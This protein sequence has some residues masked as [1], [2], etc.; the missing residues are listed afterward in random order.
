MHR[1]KHVLL[2][3]LIRYAATFYNTFLASVCLA[4]IHRFL[5]IIRICTRLSFVLKDAALFLI[6]WLYF[7]QLYMSSEKHRSEDFCTRLCNSVFGKF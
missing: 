6:T 5:A 4:E 3:V 7:D 1:T 2:K